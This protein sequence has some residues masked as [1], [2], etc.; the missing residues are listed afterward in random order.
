MLIIKNM[1]MPKGCGDCPLE[2]NLTGSYLECAYTGEY[3][4]ELDV[5][6]ADRLKN[7]PLSDALDLFLDDMKNRLIK[8]FAKNI[9]KETENND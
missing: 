2:V 5:E 9:T 7:C 4:S 6:R 1:G 8:E 3:I